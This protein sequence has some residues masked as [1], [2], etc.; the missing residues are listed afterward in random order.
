MAG[1]RNTDLVATTLLVDRSLI[2]PD[3]I[4]ELFDMRNRLVA[5]VSRQ[6]GP[7]LSTVITYSEVARAS[8]L[9]EAA[10]DGPDPVYGS[11]LQ[12]ALLMARCAARTTGGDHILLLTYSLPSAHHTDGTQPFFMEPPIAE[13]LEA[14][15]R[16]AVSAISDGLHIDILTVVPDGDEARSA[17]IN[18]FFIPMAE[19]AGGRIDSVATGQEIESVAGTITRTR[20]RH[21]PSAP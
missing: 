12:H 3:H 10:A 19:A 8:S 9:E 16:E 20:R 14:A 4:W 7:R 13:S 5:E 18:A 11:N 15:R 6:L 1:G 21:P 2:L 17:T